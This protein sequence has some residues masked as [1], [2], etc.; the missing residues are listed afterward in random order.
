M[1]N[2]LTFAT[3]EEQKHALTA[4]AEACILENYKQWSQ[5]IQVEIDRLSEM[6]SFS[7]GV[8][9]AYYEEMLQRMEGYTYQLGQGV[10]TEVEQ[11]IYRIADYVREDNVNWWQSVGWSNMGGFSSLPTD[12]VQNITSGSVYGGDW[13]LSGAI[14][15]LEGKHMQDIRDILAKGVAENMSSYDI[16]KALEQYVNP[17]AEKPWDWSKVYPGTSKKVDYNA[18][19]LART[20]IQHAYQQSLETVCRENP[21]VEKYIWRSAHTDRTCDIC[22]DMDGQEFGKGDVPLDHPN[23]LCYLEPVT[24]DRAET[25]DRLAT[26]VNGAEDLDLDRYANDMLARH[27]NIPAPNGTVN[28]KN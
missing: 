18:Q 11:D 7:A 4:E 19:R 1:P 24:A 15:N 20:L 16:A 17:G 27:Y 10:Y 12:I 23:G 2:G 3:A 21:F 5:D 6:D 26:W 25:I 13:S 8:K 22:A 28:G 9:K 14:W